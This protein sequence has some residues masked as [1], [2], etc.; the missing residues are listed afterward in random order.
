MGLIG[1]TVIPVGAIKAFAGTTAPA[2]YL[3][4]NGQYLNAT[5]NPQYLALW[6]VLSTNYY[7][8][9]GL[10]S[11]GQTHFAVPDLRGSVP[12]GNDDMGSGAA[13]RLTSVGS[14]INGVALGAYGGAQNHILALN[15][16]AAHIHPITDLGHAHSDTI[17]GVGSGT[18]GTHLMASTNSTPG[19][20]STPLASS[21][22]NQTESAP[23]F[24]GHAHLNTQPTLV[25]NY[26][27]KF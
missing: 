9:D 1:S 25:T 12:A 22:I 16:L 14:G 5:S 26:I 23:S 21:G 20:W 19:Y 10:P 17:S 24:A 8:Y 11:T 2:G 7:G 4:C 6:G 13:G 18:W 3:F 15:E 27:I